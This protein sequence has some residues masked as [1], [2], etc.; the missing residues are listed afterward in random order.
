MKRVHWCCLL[1]KGEEDNVLAEN[2]DVGLFFF[3][4]I[5]ETSQRKELEKDS[6]PTLTENRKLFF[7][8]SYDEI[9]KLSILLVFGL[10]LAKSWVW[11]HH[12]ECSWGII[13]LAT[14]FVPRSY[15]KIMWETYFPPL[16]YLSAN[17]NLY[18]LGSIQFG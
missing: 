8:N 9:N 1:G 17:S 11:H 14:F 6:C 2:I 13:T 5:M 12:T 10:R 18:Y 15:R 7:Q 4:T 16:F 3:G